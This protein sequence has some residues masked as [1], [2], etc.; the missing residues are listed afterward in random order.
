MHRQQELSI[1]RPGIEHRD[2]HQHVDQPKH[3][4]NGPRYYASARDKRPGYR[5]I[6]LDL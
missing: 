6:N 3:N 4:G 1:A 5:R 2:D